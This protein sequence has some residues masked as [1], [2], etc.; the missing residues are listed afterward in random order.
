MG[1]NII[2]IFLWSY[3]Y[4]VGYNLS[5]PYG[6]QIFHSLLHD[7]CSPLFFSRQPY[8]YIESSMSPTFDWF[9]YENRGLSIGQIE[10]KV[11]ALVFL[12]HC[13]IRVFTNF[14]YS[15]HRNKKPALD[16]NS[17]WT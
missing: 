1:F 4:E 12:G 17:M 14:P 8:P 11:C 2:I 10:D 15:P 13:G 3:T 5:S 7:H 6:M 16:D 9:L